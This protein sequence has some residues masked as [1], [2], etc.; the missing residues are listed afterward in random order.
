[1]QNFDNIINKF[2][3]NV[4]LF[5]L[6][7]QLNYKLDDKQVICYVCFIKINSKQ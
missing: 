6:N 3:Q 1:M 5:G 2:V 4:M 7:F